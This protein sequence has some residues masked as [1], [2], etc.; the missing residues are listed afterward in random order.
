MEFIDQITSA[1]DEE[2]TVQQTSPFTYF[3]KI[4][5]LKVHFVQ[6]KDY[7]SAVF[8]NEIKN[9]K[10][11]NEHFITVFED[12]YKRSPKKIIKR[13]K[14]HFGKS[15]RIHGRETK[16]TKITKPEAVEFLE[17]NHGNIPLKTKY[18]FGLLDSNKKLVAIACFGQVIRMRNG[19]KSAE[20]IRFCNLSGSRVVG[21]L[22]K[23]IGHFKNLYQLDELMTYC[24]LEWSN[25]DNF[26]KLGFTEIET[27]TPTEF[28]IN[29][30]TWERIHISQF[31]DTFNLGETN[32]KRFQTVLN[33]GSIKF[34]KYFNEK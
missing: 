24:D 16:I 34:I 13:L 19:A 10:K 22:T 15:N 11:K 31:N 30:N 29:L 7:N 20:L 4:K 33:M 23:L 1:I 9:L 32:E 5:Q 18:N 28:I 6:I 25:G 14:Y 27:S 17:K 12:Y 26:K 8:Q 3:V 2:C 21:G